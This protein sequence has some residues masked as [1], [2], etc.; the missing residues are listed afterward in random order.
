MSVSFDQPERGRTRP[1][2]RTS[3]RSGQCC[4]AQRVSPRR[5]PSS[6]RLRPGFIA[7]HDTNIVVGVNTTVATTTMSDRILDATLVAVARYGRKCSMSEIA[8]EAGVSR[9]T[10][11]R[12]YATKEALLDAL[13]EHE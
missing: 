7:T 11:Y 4:T 9:P 8:E 6:S 3:D 12:Y 5:S 2:T 10:L 1:V 13:A